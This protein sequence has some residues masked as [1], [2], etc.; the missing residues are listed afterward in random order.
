MLRKYIPSYFQ[1]QKKKTSA[2]NLL[3]DIRLN[4]VAH[5]KR[6]QSPRSAQ[7]TQVFYNHL[8]LYGR[9]K[10]QLKRPICQGSKV[11]SLLV[12]K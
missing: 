5:P 8:E 1:T 10:G 7:H 12:Y 2:N 11:N 6:D 4:L 9:A 3:N